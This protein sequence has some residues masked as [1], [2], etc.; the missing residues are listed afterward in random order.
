M[1]IDDM[2]NRIHD[3]DLLLDQNYIHNNN[4]YNDLVSEDTIRLLG[5]KYALLREDF[6]DI[7]NKKDSFDETKRIFLFYGGVDPDNLT[8]TTLKAISKF[9]TRKFE[10]DVVV[11][12]SNSNI[13]IIKEEMKIC[14]HTVKLY[15]QIDNIADLMIKADIAIGA[16]GSTTWE[17]IAAGLP[18]IVVTLA[19]NQIDFTRDLAQ[20]GYLHWIGSANQVN[21]DVIHNALIG[22]IKDQINLHKKSI[23]NKKLVDGMGC[24]RVSNLLTR[25][26][27][28]KKILDKR[29]VFL[30]TIISDSD[31]WMSKWIDQ[32]VV[33]WSIL[34]HKVIW[35]NEPSKIP[36]G[37][38][39]FIL[40]CSSH[41]KSD[42]L[43][44]NSHNLVVHESDLPKGRGWSP[45]S[46]QVL[47]GKS[48]IPV[49]LFEAES[50]IDSGAIYLQDTIKLRGNELVKDLRDKQASITINLCNK[51][52]DNYP[53][54]LNK[55]RNQTGSPSF[56]NR[57]VGA[58]SRIDINKTIKDQF[59]LLRIVDNYKYP[60]FFD[61]LGQRYY[62]NIKK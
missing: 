2:A 55:S 23:N 9:R 7:E 46:W 28:N 33:E 42:V 1:V 53:Y 14:P 6:I 36:S 40:S 37:D 31:T 56:Y 30:I 34:G 12:S 4:R 59:N 51:F 25:A 54:I 44:K 3:C 50:K 10:I 47:E 35:V 38:F 15:V 39:C 43:K 13:D 27:N 16:G 5:P 49:T 52:I 61:Y 26:I 21:E 62:I 57:R 19:D 11:G 60:A 20:D 8:T 58:D 45:L 48:I 32:L 29:N 24:Y 41:I 18:S 22:A 17:R